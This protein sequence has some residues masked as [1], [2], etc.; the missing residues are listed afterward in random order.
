MYRVCILLLSPSVSPYW[1]REFGGLVYGEEEEEED[2]EGEE[3]EEDPEP[4]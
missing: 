3:E 4:S 2:E 1:C